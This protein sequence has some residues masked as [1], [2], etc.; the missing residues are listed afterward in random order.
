EHDG[1]KTNSLR[2][3]SV[4]LDGDVRFNDA[5]R[6]RFQRAANACRSSRD[7]CKEEVRCTVLSGR[8][9]AR[10]FALSSNAARSGGSENAVAQ[11]TRQIVATSLGHESPATVSSRIVDPFGCAQDKPFIR[12]PQESSNLNC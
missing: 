9:T 1:K 2:T 7:L 3:D 11:R 12:S 5:F 4:F 6:G 10:H 8:E